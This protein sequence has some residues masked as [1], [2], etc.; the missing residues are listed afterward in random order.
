MKGP[1][2]R[3]DFAGETSRAEESSSI[4]SWLVNLLGFFWDEGVFSL[5]AGSVRGGIHAQLRDRQ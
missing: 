2:L 3:I 4:Y 1:L 5:G